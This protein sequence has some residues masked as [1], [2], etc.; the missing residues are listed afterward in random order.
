VDGWWAELNRSVF[1]T[2]LKN[3]R[4]AAWKLRADG[5]AQ[6]SSP[7][8]WNRNGEDDPQSLRWTTAG[9]PLRSMTSGTVRPAPAR[10]AGPQ[11]PLL[12]AEIRW[13]PLL[14]N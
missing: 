11:P 9:M 6:P 4:V 8:A 5:V 10:C 12:A 13:L 1:S 14:P 3:L 7:E 2:R